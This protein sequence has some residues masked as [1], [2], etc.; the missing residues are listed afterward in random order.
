MSRITEPYFVGS[1]YRNIINEDPLLPL[2][3]GS[4]ELE[5][6]ANL[7]AQQNNDVI[8]VRFDEI[9]AAYETQIQA[10][11]QTL[12]AEILPRRSSTLQEVD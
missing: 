11:I 12:E 2:V 5:L 9:R 10:L 7:L 3:D 6:A 1:V 4:Q 8:Q